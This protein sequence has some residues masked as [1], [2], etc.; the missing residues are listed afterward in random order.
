MENPTDEQKN[1]T[2]VED[3][4]VVEDTAEGALV[5][6]TPQ[7]SFGLPEEIATA[8][9]F[10]TLLDDAKSIIVEHEFT[11]RWALIEGYHALGKRIL[12]EN[13][14][15]NRTA[16]YGKG[17]VNAISQSIGKNP[18]SVHYAVAFARQFE[19]LDSLP[20]GKN[21]SWFKITQKY[22]PKPKDE[23]AKEEKPKK[24][25]PEKVDADD[26]NAPE[27]AP[28]PNLSLQWNKES[29]LWELTIDPESFVFLDVPG[30]KRQ[31]D[32]YLES[33]KA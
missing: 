2:S 18:R 31:I 15:L 25:A 32:D 9:W 12:E 21:V 17:I 8:E 11:S 26:V 33:L 3:G 29:E 27:T 22:L 16:T 6:D 5:G 10:T 14:N 23:D 24:T 1:L 19:N 13:D 4:E 7:N 30:L 28:R 20:E